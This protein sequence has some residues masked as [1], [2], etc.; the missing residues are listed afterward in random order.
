MASCY[1]DV[2]KAKAMLGW[3]AKLD[4]MICAP[5]HGAGKAETQTVMM[6][7]QQK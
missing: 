2:G 6:D 4:I 5:T 7:E 1:A 3:E